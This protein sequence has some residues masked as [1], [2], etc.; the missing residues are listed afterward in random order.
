MLS[1]NEA[2]GS[3][4]VH[5][6]LKNFLFKPSKMKMFQVLYLWKLGPVSF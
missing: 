4:I 5:P 3:S 1:R 6:Y 2:D